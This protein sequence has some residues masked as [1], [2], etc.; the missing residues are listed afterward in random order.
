MGLNS[1]L[2]I[3]FP[4]SD[5]E[6]VEAVMPIAPEVLQPFGFLHGGA[7]VSLL[8]AAAS[9]GAQNRADLERERPFGIDVHVRHRKGA[10]SG[11][12]RA[13]AALER[14]EVSERT[15]SRTQHWSVAAY[16]DEGDVVS[17]G[18]VVTKVVSLAYLA[19]REAERASASQTPPARADASAAQETSAD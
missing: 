16:D 10:R 17:D 2:H 1:L 15:G 19:R 7:T 13:V 9:L 6:R 4:V 12:L 14:E 8:E 3:E 11:M 5:A 18:S